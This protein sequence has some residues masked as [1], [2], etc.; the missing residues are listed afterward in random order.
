MG[1][2]RQPGDA[3]PQVAR[4]GN[5]VLPS[6]PRAA[7]PDGLAER[8]SNR[9]GARR[10]PALRAAFVGTADR[11]RKD[12]QSVLQREQAHTGFEGGHPAVRRAR[13]LGKQDE[14]GPSPHFRQA[15]GDGLR[16][17]TVP[18]HGDG[19]GQ[20]E[21][22]LLLPGMGEEV[23]LRAQ[24]AEAVDLPKGERREQGQRIEVAG[25]IGHDDVAAEVLQL[26]VVARAKA[27]EH[28]QVHPHENVGEDPQRS[29]GRAVPHQVQRRRRRT[30]VPQ[31]HLSTSHRF[32]H[33]PGT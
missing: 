33:W 14:V 1:L 21:G 19:V 10:K 27:V 32:R 7:V 29:G 25:V 8:H 23:V 4:N 2:D 6:L 31:H 28:S 18:V 22:D 15:V 16:I 12:R 24:G 9:P 5:P 3:A 13:A 20:E 26:A 17:E 30:V 11:G